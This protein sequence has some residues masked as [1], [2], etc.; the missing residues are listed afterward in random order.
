M[1]RKKRVVKESPNLKN[2]IHFALKNLLLFLIIFIM[3][4]IFYFFSTN[5]LLKNLFGILAIIF[6]FLTFAFLLAWIVLLILGTGK[7]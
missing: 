3:S 2:R 5:D 1:A 4:F 6:G 7:K